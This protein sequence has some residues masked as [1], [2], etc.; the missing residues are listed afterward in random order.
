[1]L[2]LGQ[3]ETRIYFKVR[4]QQCNKNLRR[5]R[6]EMQSMWLPIAIN[7]ANPTASLGNTV[8]PSSSAFPPL[9]KLHCLA[10]TF[11]LLCLWLG[12]SWACAFTTRKQEVKP[13]SCTSPS[14]Q[15]VVSLPKS[16]AII[17]VSLNLSVWAPTPHCCCKVPF[18]SES[19]AGAKNCRDDHQVRMS[20]NRY[21]HTW[22]T[23][24]GTIC[25]RRRRVNKALLLF[26]L[27]SGPPRGKSMHCSPASSSVMKAHLRPAQAVR[28]GVFCSTTFSMRQ[29]VG[30]CG[31][32]S[33]THF[34]RAISLLHS[35][36]HPLHLD[37]Q[38]L[39]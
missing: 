27:Y 17:Q 22:N 3:D 26:T 25:F 32:L 4:K 15:I 12:Q 28:G 35:S 29:H 39:D 10:S 6:K 5:I 9:L 19:T 38:I 33:K 20:G 13:L 34:L 31:R 14:P 30:P 24:S 8:S 11:C 36:K 7:C 23:V 21:S 16:I 18:S 1:M 2:Q 37:Q